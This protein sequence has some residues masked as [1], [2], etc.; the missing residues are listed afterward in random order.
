MFGSDWS[1]I[2][3]LVQD[4]CMGKPMH[5][6]LKIAAIPPGPLAPQPTLF[7]WQGDGEPANSYKLAALFALAVCILEEPSSPPEGMQDWLDMFSI[8][9]VSHT[10]HATWPSKLSTPGIWSA[11]HSISLHHLP[12]LIAQYHCSH[13][14]SSLHPLLRRSRQCGHSTSVVA[15]KP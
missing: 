11:H 9:S 13:F 15:E 8:I 12:S 4:M 10:R 3:V 6:R 5:Q 1:P 14:R 2:E 7:G